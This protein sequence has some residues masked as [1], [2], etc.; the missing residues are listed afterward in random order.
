MAKIKLTSDDGANFYDPN[1]KIDFSNSDQLLSLPIGTR[2]VVNST[3]QPYNTSTSGWFTKLQRT[4]DVVLIKY[5]PYNSNVIYQKRFYK[6]WSDWEQ[7]GL[8]ITDS[9]W[10]SLPLSNGAKVIDTMKTISYLHIDL[11]ITEKVNLQRY[12]GVLL[13]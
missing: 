1:L 9:G 12:K 11:L 2:Y 8:N 7:V 13:T 3:N 10:L 5:Q 6:I 4:N